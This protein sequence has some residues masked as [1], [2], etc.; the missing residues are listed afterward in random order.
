LYSDDI[1][2]SPALLNA[3][4]LNT[5]ATGTQDSWRNLGGNWNYPPNNGAYPGTNTHSTVEPGNVLRHYGEVKPKS[6]FLTYAD[7]LPENLSLMPCTRLADYTDYS[8]LK[9]VQFETSVIAP[10]HGSPGGA[11][12]FTNRVIDKLIR[13]EILE[14]IKR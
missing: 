1:A 13:D 12:Q 14:E 11:V 5:C 7:T 2:G 3:Q 4:Q 6:R 9:P 10:W 8:V